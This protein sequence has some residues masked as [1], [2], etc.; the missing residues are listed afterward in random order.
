MILIAGATGFVGRA[1]LA[2]LSARGPRP[3]R[4]LVRREFDA[5][6]LRDQGVEALTGDLIA[7][8]GLDAAMRG[9]LNHTLADAN[10]ALGLARHWL[11]STNE[12]MERLGEVLQL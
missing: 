5:V 11:D 12:L 3:V 2:E 6:R 8:T 9:V 7:G 1:L 10:S 4:A